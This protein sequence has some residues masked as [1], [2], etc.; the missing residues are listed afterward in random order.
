MPSGPPSSCDSS[1]AVYSMLSSREAG[2]QAGRRSKASCIP[3]SC[4]QQELAW[5]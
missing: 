4:C 5:V 3:T 1:S 2:C